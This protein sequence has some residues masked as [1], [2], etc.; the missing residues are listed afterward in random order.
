MLA[1]ELHNKVRIDARVRGDEQA[2]ERGL[3]TTGFGLRDAAAA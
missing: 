1:A 3:V 2:G